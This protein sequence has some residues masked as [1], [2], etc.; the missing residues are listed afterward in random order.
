MS[1][2]IGLPQ[3]F[4][5]PEYR[6]QEYYQELLNR[7]LNDWFNVN[8]GFL[9]PTFSNAEIA[10]IAATYP[11]VRIWYNSDLD[12]LQFVGSSGIQTITSV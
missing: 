6:M 9:L 1:G 10:A 12:K 3:Y 7:M 2:V 5:N 4:H 8:T 11:P